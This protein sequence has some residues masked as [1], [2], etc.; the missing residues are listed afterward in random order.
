MGMSR[1]SRYASWMFAIALLVAGVLLPGQASH[2]Q[3]ATTGMMVVK[4]D[5]QGARLRESPSATSAV[6]GVIPEG[7]H[8]TAS[9]STIEA[10]ARLWRF[11][12]FGSLSGYVADEFLTDLCEI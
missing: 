5:G 2:A 11:V 3:D 9:T 1:R 12:T 8:V 10:E 4:T 6:L 7:A